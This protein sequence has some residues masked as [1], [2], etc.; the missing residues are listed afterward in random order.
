MKQFPNGLLEGGAG[1]NRF[2]GN[3]GSDTV[4]YD[5]SDAGVSVNLTTGAATGGH[6]TGDVLLDI[7]NLT[8]SNFA[9]ALTGDLGNNVPMGGGDDDHLNGMAGDDRLIGGAGNDR[10]EG[11]EGDDWLEGGI[12]AD[13]SLIH[14]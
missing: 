14:I 8:G 11:G 2:E 13:L 7:E 1:A 12:G 6:A 10:L 4:S 3:G 9:D 5:S